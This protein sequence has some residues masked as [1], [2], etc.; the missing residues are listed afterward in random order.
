MMIVAQML[1]AAF[2][3]TSSSG[4]KLYGVLFQHS[5]TDVEKVFDL[6]DSCNMVSNQLKTLTKDFSTCKESAYGETT[7][8]S[9]C[10]SK[11][12]AIKGLQEIEKEAKVSTK[13]QKAVL[14]LTDGT[15]DDPNNE[16][17]T[18]KSSLKLAGIETIIAARVGTDQVN[19]NLKKYANNASNAIVAD[20][21]LE[22]GRKIVERLSAEGIL[23][24]DHGKNFQ[25]YIVM[26]Q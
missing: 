20:E 5:G 22:L 8:K 4:T 10:A 18:V 25:V 1:A 14:I 19:D 12:I 6:G 16:L 15:I 7:F 11:T 13:E 17:G 26:F 21:P 3:P 9:V 2:N 23:C 24:N